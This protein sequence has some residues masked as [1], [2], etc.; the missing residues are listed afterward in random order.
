M[1]KVRRSAP[2][3]QN[4]SDRCRQRPPA[5]RV[6]RSRPSGWCSSALWALSLCLACSR[7]SRPCSTGAPSTAPQQS[8]SIVAKRCGGVVLSVGHARVR[9]LCLSPLSAVAT[10]SWFGG[11]GC[12]CHAQAGGRGVVGFRYMRLRIWLCI[13]GAW[14]RMQEGGQQWPFRVLTLVW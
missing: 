12:L 11:Y 10:V 8:R 5:D 1:K 7:T 2:C 3:A 14:Q 6:E 13:R 4:D 9:C